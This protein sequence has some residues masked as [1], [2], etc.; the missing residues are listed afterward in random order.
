M[1]EPDRFVALSA[2]LDAPLGDVIVSG[3][4]HKAGGP[5]GGGYGLIVRDEG[6]GPRDGVNQ[7]GRYYVL[8]V[9]DKGEFGIWRRE[10]DQWITL[11]PWTQTEA[12]H[13][14]DEVNEL[15]VFAAGPKLTFVVNGIIIATQTDSSLAE[16][17]VG[18]F[19]GG[20]LNQV[21]LQHLTVQ[22]PD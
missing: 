10:E 7:L 18:I 21:T 19:V 16:G 13:T 2:P 4:F 11:I 5:A 12:V 17:M 9:G 20:D 15:V 6:P 22:V 3:T 1:R 14:G 8:E